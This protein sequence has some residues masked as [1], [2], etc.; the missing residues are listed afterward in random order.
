MSGRHDQRA[1]WAGCSLFCWRDLLGGLEGSPSLVPLKDA[2][3]AEIRAI[4]RSGCE[5]DFLVRL[6][7]IVRADMKVS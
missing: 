6:T 2:K 5:A 1:H 3:N 4:L 7:G